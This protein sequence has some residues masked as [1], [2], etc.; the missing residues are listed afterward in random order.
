MVPARPG[1]DAD[2]L[3]A[4][5][6][7]AIDVL[8]GVCG[9]EHEAE[10]GLVARDRGEAD[11]GGEDAV[12]FEDVGDAVDFAVVADVP[13]NDGSV[14]EDLAAKFPHLKINWIPRNQNLAGKML[15]S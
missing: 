9:H 13:G 4:G 10:D 8:F 7:G 15:G 12:P 5:V 2:G 14:A 11:G 3:G 6:E 1:S